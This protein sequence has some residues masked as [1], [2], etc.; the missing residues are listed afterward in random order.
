[1]NEF[2]TS[3]WNVIDLL[4]WSDWATLAIL[5]TFLVL[6]FK[7]GMAKELINLAFLLLAIVL[8]WL[9]YQPLAT[10]KAVTWLLLSHQS[11]MAIAFGILF[12]GVLL[13]KKSLYKLTNISS[14][15]SNPCA[16]NKLFAYFVFLSITA[17][18]SWY[19]LDI[20]ANLGIMEIVVTNSSTRVGLAFTITFAIIIGACVGLSNMLNISIDSSKPCV[21][22]TLFKKI[23]DTLHALDRL[24]NAKNISGNSNNFGG[25]LVG[26]IKGSLAILIMVLVFQ[27]IDSI[28]QQHY[29]I[30][31]NGALRFFQDIASDIKPALSEH[32]L[33]IVNE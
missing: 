17:T 29:W 9:F 14:Q 12:V 5:I 21:L 25:L 23:L 16:L 10:S 3:I 2:F 20:I 24:L 1:M 18:L 7:R 4:V 22:S 6:G 13:I 30:E 11:H 15:I 19:Y 33:F 8:A 28:S 27:S 31:A 32:L 26:L